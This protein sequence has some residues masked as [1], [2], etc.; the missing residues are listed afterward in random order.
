MSEASSN[1]TAE[2]NMIGPL[3]ET[4]RL[5]GHQVT[6]ERFIS[7]LILDAG[8]TGDM[9]AI[10]R[11]STD[12]IKNWE[13][14]H[15]ANTV[16]HLV[17]AAIKLARVNYDQQQHIIAALEERN[18]ELELGL[19]RAAHDIRSP[20]GRIA[21]ATDIL[22]YEHL[23]QEGQDM[24]DMINRGALY[25]TELIE[26]VMEYN[27]E[28]VPNLMWTNLYA[29]ALEASQMVVTDEDCIVNINVPEYPV[30]IETDHAKVTRIVQ[31][32][33][34][35]AIKYSCPAHT[36][37][38]QGVIDVYVDVLDDGRGMIEIADNGVGISQDDIERIFSPFVRTD[39][40]RDS[41]VQ[42]LGL[43]LATV[44][45]LTDALGIEIQIGSEVGV[46]TTFTLILPVYE[47]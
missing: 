16:T 42:G 20:L 6:Y 23:S 18:T 38:A 43:G 7:G 34:N 2:L 35:N 10:H 3:G 26:Q 12:I 11:F 31:N 21:S 47:Q 22:S 45:K 19:A 40:A 8:R 5:N 33:V 17:G 41:K 25:A 24:L 4:D 14:E 27:Q 32:L 9:T 28:I 30:D 15:A 1:G 29:L 44:Q 36:G 37:K 13:P 39:S 46:G